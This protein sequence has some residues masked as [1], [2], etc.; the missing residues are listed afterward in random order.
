MI[1]H[2]MKLNPD[3][4]RNVA[5]IYTISMHCRYMFTL[6]PEINRA[7][8]TVE[9]DCIL[10][11]AIKEY[12]LNFREFPTNLLPGRNMK[13]IRSRYNNVLKHVNVR[14][15]WTEEHDKKL[16]KLVERHGNEWVKIADEMVS[17][18]RTSCRQRY[19]T[20]QKFLDK[21][22]KK[23]ISDVPRRKRAF[24]TNV[25]TENWME[26][27]IE[28][29]NFETIEMDEECQNEQTSKPTQPKQQKQSSAVVKASN[30]NYNMPYYD[31]F[32][33]SFNFKLGKTVAGSDA[34]FENIQIACQ[35][36]QAPTL[37]KQIDILNPSFSSYV[38]MPENAK[39]IQ[40][41]RELIHSLLQ[42]GKNEFLFPVNLNTILGM[43]A[44]TI[45]FE[46]NEKKKSTAQTV[47]KETKNDEHNAL[48]LFK[49]RFRSIFK[50]T[51]AIAKMKRSFTS[52]S[53]RLRSQKRQ[54]TN[55]ELTLPLSVDSDG[56]AT[57]QDQSNDGPPPKRHRTIGMREDILID[58]NPIESD[59]YDPIQ[60]SQ[61]S[62]SSEFTPYRYRV[63]TSDNI[64][65]I[66]IQPYTA[67]ESGNDTDADFVA[68]DF[69]IWTPISCEDE[70]TSST[71]I[72]P[73]Q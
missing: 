71:T 1:D 54:Q 40:L 49:T 8:F 26:T 70:A 56:D 32:K 12:G 47:K 72:Q 68:T 59:S 51:A 44:L 36:L 17:H 60:T 30:Y 2:D 11:A 34:L 10:M 39:K 62:T 58:S 38:I 53:L 63:T 48:N 15:H 22:P 3:I 6:N 73:H 16:M 37:P 19:T 45:M 66:N 33:Y 29:K 23:T 7:P 14:E 25:T 42:L 41:E 55:N 52:V 65:A 24:S 9:E 5:L 21:N 43:R 57:I 61:A 18:S 69:V 31:F 13:Q 35:L 20:I 27:I 46:A 67:S 64:Q 50:H 4:H 28:A